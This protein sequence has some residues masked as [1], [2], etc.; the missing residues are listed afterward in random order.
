M[1]ILAFIMKFL[2]RNFVVCL[3]GIL[4]L[5]FE[6]QSQSTDLDKQLGA[7]NAQMV[8]AQMGIYNDAKKTA[9]IRSVG[10]RLLAQLDKPLFDYQFH[11]VPDKSPNAF[12]LPGGYIYITT[13]L[14][15]ILESED[16]LACIMAHEIIHSNNRHTIKQLKKSI[17][18][19]L[20]EVPGNL[21]GALDEDLGA[22]FNAPIQTSN[23]LLFASY[24]RSFETESDVQ[25]IAL[26]AAAGYDPNAMISAL[27]RLSLT[28]EVAIGQKETKSYFNDHPY[29][30]DRVNTIEKNSQNLNWQSK[31]A[32][33]TDFL[34]EFDSLLFGDSPALGIIRNNQF[35]HPD[36]DFT[37]SF[38]KGWDIEN[39]PTN[40]G[41]YDPSRKAA[42]FVSI[43]PKGQ[44]IPVAA[45]EFIDALDPS[46]KKLQ[47]ANEAIEIN[48]QQ[49]H[50]ISFEE[51]SGETTM[52]AYV[53]WLPING[54]LF[55]LIGITPIEYRPLLEQAANSLRV[56]TE[57]EKKSI[58][59]NLVRVVKANKGETIE[60]LS[61]RTGNLIK[62][63]LTGVINDRK[64][65]EVLK[66]NEEIKVVLSSKYNKP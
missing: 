55:K 31:K 14:I 2:F 47:T 44:T 38:P 16:E 30:P 48:G 56:L 5:T 34:N 3:I 15:P 37:L 25:G 63:D 42:M 59:I 28:I 32:I 54:N 12:A 39:Q 27:S 51:T 29:T 62:N 52:Y 57:E 13:G 8:E 35:L 9:Y 66:M 41:A 11:I 64:T 21:I 20:L 24:G 46:Y 1:S 60:S 58:K 50:L 22:L 65:T 43:E 53:L 17:L 26:A 10:E 19:R 18:P 40:V 45:S 36:I 23:A 49:G 7:E 33:S 4:L 6:A 61:I